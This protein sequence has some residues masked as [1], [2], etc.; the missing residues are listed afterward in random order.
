MIGNQMFD[1]RDLV[2]YQNKMKGRR[3]FCSN[4][5]FE[6][7]WRHLKDHMRGQNNNGMFDVVRVDIF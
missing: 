2:D 1:E 5:S 7:N 3:I 4:L 6:T